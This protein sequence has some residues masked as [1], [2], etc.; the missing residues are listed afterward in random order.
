MTQLPATASSF[1]RTGF[2][3]R[4]TAVRES[5]GLSAPAFSDRLGLPHRTY[6]TWER[7][8]ADPPARLLLILGRDYGID[9][10][11]LMDGPGEEIRYAG[12]R[13]DWERFERLKSAVVDMAKRLHLKPGEDRILGVVRDVFEGPESEDTKTLSHIERLWRA[14]GPTDE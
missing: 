12:A 8:E 14:A 3:R 6:L 7:E 5:L 2:G 1:K 11:W 4:L 13:V 9:L 10:I